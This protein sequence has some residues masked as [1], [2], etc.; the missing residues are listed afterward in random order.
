VP[1]APMPDEK[2]DLMSR[3]EREHWWFRAKQEL[4]RERVLGVRPAGR[5]AVDVGCGTGAV[6]AML[7]GPGGYQTVVGTDLSQYALRL[8]EPAVGSHGHVAASRAEALPFAA[9]SIG[10]LTSLDVV[11]HLDDAVL[12]LREYAR[13][14]APDGVMCLTVPAYLWAWSD[15]DV[16]LGHRTRYTKRRLLQTA[17]EAGLDVQRCTYFH[18]WLAPL[19]LLLRRTPLRRLM[20]KEA[21]EAS[22]VS[23]AVNRLLVQI[24]RLERALIR[25]LDM[26]FGLSLFLVAGPGRNAGRAAPPARPG[27]SDLATDGK[28]V[29][30]AA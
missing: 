12:A 26:P 19:A 2:F 9:G 5:A 7:G 28:S 24:V 13:V 23:P 30:P 20:K 18:S 21:E 22:F 1:Q 10:C 14:L 27:S 11:E 4:V 17:R 16:V 15:H 6:V 3:L 8:A 25:R 29:R